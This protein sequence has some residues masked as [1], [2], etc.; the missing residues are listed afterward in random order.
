MQIIIIIVNDWSEF[1]NLLQIM[2][3]EL[4]NTV[5]LQFSSKLK[6]RK[7]WKPSIQN[8][9]TKQK[10]AQIVIGKN[11]YSASTMI[12][13]EFNTSYNFAAFDSSIV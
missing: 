11:K 1:P 8:V 7:R 13:T 6:A 12:S 3:V 9:D 5:T 10:I 2:G 4:D